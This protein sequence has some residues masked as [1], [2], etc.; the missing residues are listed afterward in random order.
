MSDL[1]VTGYSNP[2]YSSAD[3]QAIDC[4]LT[5]AD[6]KTI[7]FTASPVD[8]APHGKAI[9]AMIVSN[10]AKVPIAAYIPPPAMTVGKEPT[11][12]A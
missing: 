8:P 12:L 3:K 7:P 5:L 11:Q 2:V 9:Y 6:G 10:A 4:T 1:V